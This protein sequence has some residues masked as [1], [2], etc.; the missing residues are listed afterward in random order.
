MAH[1]TQIEFE[2]TFEAAHHLPD[3]KGLT[4]KKCLNNHGHTYGVRVFVEAQ[5]LTDDFVVDFGTI[6]STIDRLD[7]AQLLW[8]EDEKW[9][10]FMENE[11][12]LMT[13]VYLPYPPTAEN[14]AHY[15]FDSLCDEM[16]V[17]ALVTEVWVAEGMKPGKVAWVKYRE[18]EE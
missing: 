8:T 4:T 11:N 5:K 14:I 16:P 1:L 17:D 10:E 15:I 7:H 3:S 13:T 6:K 18:V 2:H 9:T 12:P